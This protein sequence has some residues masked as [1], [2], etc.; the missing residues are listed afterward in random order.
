VDACD[1]AILTSKSRVYT[2]NFKHV[3]ERNIRDRLHR[4]HDGETP[5]GYSP[6]NVHRLR[7]QLGL[8]WQE[9]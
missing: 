1:W 9:T 6:E 5:T 3:A 4:E 7:H 2:R 8:D